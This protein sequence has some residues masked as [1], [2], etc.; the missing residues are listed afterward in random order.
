VNSVLAKVQVL[1]KF[2][3][4]GFFAISISKEH[5]LINLSNFSFGL[6]SLQS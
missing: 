2:K 1:D 3:P 5:M 6:L 4:Y